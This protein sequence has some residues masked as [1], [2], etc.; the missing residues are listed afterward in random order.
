MEENKNTTPAEPPKCVNKGKPVWFSYAPNSDENPEWS[1]IA[2]CVEQLTDIFKAQNI[3]YCINGTWGSNASISE[4]EKNIGWK[5]DVIVLV[6]SDRYFRSLH[7]MYEFVQIKN[8]IKENPQKRL[9]CIKS[10]DFNL[11]DI[12]YILDLEHFWGDQKQEYDEVSYHKTR[13]ITNAEEEAHNNGFYMDDIRSL[14]SFFSTLNYANAHSQ[15]WNDFA[16]EIADSYTSVSKF[17]QLVQ[18]KVKQRKTKLKFMGLGCLTW[19]LV[20]IIALAA[21]MVYLL[22]GF[23]HINNPVYPQKIDH[24]EIYSI[25]QTTQ[26]ISLKIRL[27]NPYDKDTIIYASRGWYI[28]ANGKQNHLR[29]TQDIPMYPEYKVLAAHQST[30]YILTFD[31]IPVPPG[32]MTLVM[33]HG[34]SINGI[35]FIERYIPTT[36]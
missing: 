9:F 25:T 22:L 13:P 32:S 8:A 29:L 10:G 18:E 26:G 34:I 16:K 31:K 28:E 3:E 20:P 5:S 27:T 7:C 33:S 11:S 36:Q 12:N 2:D 1:H 6:F 21:L 4:Y 24:I 14:Y 30:E 17:S 19:L 23:E 15:D 35:K